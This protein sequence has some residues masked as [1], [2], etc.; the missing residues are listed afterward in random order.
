MEP[1]HPPTTPRD[2]GRSDPVTPAAAA[3]AASAAPGR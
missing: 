3:L 1:F 2:G